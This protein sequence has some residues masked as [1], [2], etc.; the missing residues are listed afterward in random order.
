MAVPGRNACEIKMVHQEDAGL[1]VEMAKLAFA[2]GIWSYM[3]KMNDALR[4]YTTIDHLQPSSTVNAIGL[5]QEV[6]DATSFVV[7]VSMGI[8]VASFQDKTCF[9]KQLPA[10]C[11]LPVLLFLLSLFPF[12]ASTNIG[13]HN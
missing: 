2:K 12:V 8:Y 4:K 3:S 13:I 10:T 1:N 11:V 6:R 5:F 9:C 7:A